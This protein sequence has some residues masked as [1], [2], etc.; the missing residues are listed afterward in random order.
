MAYD[1]RSGL[2]GIPL[3]A[4]THI[5][6]DNMSVVHNTSRPESKSKH[7]AYH[8]IRESVAAQVIKIVHEVSQEQYACEFQ[9][10]ARAQETR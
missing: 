4:A 3:D 7:I 1:I 6:V 2:M 5:L 10:R 9:T 8:F